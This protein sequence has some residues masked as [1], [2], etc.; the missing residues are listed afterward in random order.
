ML[1]IFCGKYCAA[2]IQMDNDNADYLDGPSDGIH[3]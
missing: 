1:D 3:A 2:G